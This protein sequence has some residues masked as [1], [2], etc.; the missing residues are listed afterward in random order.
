MSPRISKLFILLLMLSALLL[1]AFSAEAADLTL[2]VYMSG[3]NLETVHGAATADIQEMIDALP[4]DDSLNVILMAAGAEIWQTDIDPESTNIYRISKTGLEAVSTAPLTSMGSAESLTRLLAYA[5]AE[6]P[7]SHYALIF[8][9]H[10]AGPMAGLCFDELYYDE[11]GQSMDR[12]T[13]MELKAALEA[14]PFREEKLSWIGMDACLMASVETAAI[15]APYSDYL[16]ASEETEPSRG[17]NYGFL[18]DAAKARTAEVPP[19]VS[20]RPMRTPIRALSKTSRFPP[21]IFTIYPIWYRAFRTLQ[22]R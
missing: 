2:M 4:E 3:G 15:L 17:W 20:L 12:L 5:H 21:S 14:S 10:G 7:A 13:L 11:D 8:W 9:D 19:S 6:F 16:I 18:K 1:F 22:K